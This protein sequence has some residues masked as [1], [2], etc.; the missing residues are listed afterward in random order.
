MDNLSEKMISVEEAK[1]A[2]RCMRLGDLNEDEALECLDEF[3]FRIRNVTTSKI[4]EEII[5]NE[6]TPLQS[7]IMKMYLYD[8]LGVVQIGRIIGMSQAAVSKTMFRANNTIIKYLSPLIKY[9]DDI[10]DAKLIPLRVG[11][12]LEISA[13]KNGNADSFGEA[14][15]N[16]RVAYDISPERLSSNL[17]ISKGELAA[18]ESGRKIPSVTTAMRYSAL[19][20]VEIDMKF[21]NGRG[22][23]LCKRP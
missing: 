13:A 9:Q 5:E 20:N 8:N 21:I 4:V 18:I 2:L 7:E 10:T 15:R 3:V 23:Y 12:L 14:L 6:L 19:F 1:T 22:F 17:N 16:L 11:K